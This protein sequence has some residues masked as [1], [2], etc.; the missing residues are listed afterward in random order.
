MTMVVS[1]EALD[2]LRQVVAHW[3]EEHV[4]VSGLSDA[5]EMAEHVRRVCGEAAIEQALGEVTGRSTYAGSRIPCDCGGDARFVGYRKRWLRTVCAEVE[6]ERAYYHCGGC[7]SGRLP[8]DEEQGLSQL[9]WT[10]RLKALV[11][12]VS[13]R[14][15]YG[16]TSRLMEL[17][18]VV[19]IEESSAEGIVAEVG[20]R[21]REEEERAVSVYQARAEAS[22]ACQLWCEDEE[23]SVV[24]LP[25]EKP[26]CGE[27]LYVSMDAAKAHIDAEWHDVKVGVVSTA[28][29]GKDGLDSVSERSYV[30]QRR[31]AEGFGW[32][33]RVRAQAW[34]QPDYKQTVFLADGADYNWN[35][36]AYHF[37]GAVQIL[38]FWHAC[39][40]IG[41]LSRLLYDP[42]HAA[43]AARGQRWAK[44]RMESLKRDGHRPL[45]RA[46]KRR[47]PKSPQARELLRRELGYFRRNQKRMDYPAYRRAGMMIGSGL[48]EAGC[49]VVVAQRMKHA[50]MRWSSRG[51]DAMLAVRTAVLSHDYDRLRQN[52]RAA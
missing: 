37:P 40:H 25:V 8:W 26:V 33:L 46:L 31:E 28:M 51:A 15:T 13:A 39:E 27:R 17:L 48:V 11:A 44:E 12:E 35:Q 36:A 23:A 14:T 4:H 16:E 19:R 45:L 1:S 38:D 47:K 21:L 30:A 29:V 41:T 9:M 52:A 7:H 3:C 32:L 49:K 42:G 5:E 20:A 43:E 10:P 2:S 24:A 50:G 34:S 6:V 22:L 18:G